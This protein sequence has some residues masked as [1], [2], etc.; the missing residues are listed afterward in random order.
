MQKNDLIEI[1]MNSVL[2]KVQ[3]ALVC[4][5]RPLRPDEVPKHR[6]QSTVYEST[7]E[8]SP[9]FLEKA[10][11]GVPYRATVK[12][13]GTCAR[14]GEDGNYYRRLDL[15]KGKAPPE[16][17]LCDSENPDVCWLAVTNDPADKWHASARNPDG[18]W[19]VVLP[20]GCGGQ[21]FVP[22]GE[23]S[24][25]VY[26]EVKHLP[27]GTYELVGPKIQSNRYRLPEVPKPVPR[28]FLVRHG[29]FVL[30]E[31]L[32]KDRDF[33]HLREFVV[34]CA[35]EGIVYHFA[36]GSLFKINR[37]HLNRELSPTT[38]LRFGLADEG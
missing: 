8:W 26:G 14:I 25:A 19:N 29:A 32:A 21:D 18:S 2:G 27:P 15:H 16:N 11:S 36:D 38:P 17:A 12:I 24:G 37:G 30:P 6:G 9:A 35:L 22:L 23:T 34:G 5:M 1:E 7:G 28:H 3:S 4:A 33:E 20:K 10:S 31:E 13:D